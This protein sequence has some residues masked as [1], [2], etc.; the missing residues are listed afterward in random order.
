MIKI[1]FQ[2]PTH[3]EWINWRIECE[4]AQD[5]LNGNFMQQ[6]VDARIYKR[7][8]EQVYLSLTGPFRGKCAYCEKLIATDQHGDMEHYRPKGAVKDKSGRSI[9]ITLN[10]LEQGHPGYYWLAY[11]WR[12]LLPSC[13]LCNQGNIRR[14]KTWT[15]GKRNYFPLVSEDDRAKKPGEEIHEQPLLINPTF[16]DPESFIGMQAN[17]VLF[18]KDGQRG[19]GQTCIE[20]F[21]LNYKGLREERERTYKDTLNLMALL[22]NFM[23][24]DPNAA[25]TKDMADRLE[26]IKEGCEEFTVAARLAVKDVSQRVAPLM[27]PLI[28]L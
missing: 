6:E 16:E 10:D 13:Q 25:S 9:K 14:G 22:L 4:Q 23:I 26:R 28:N 15:A 18:A 8:K 24:I 3:E 1:N 17:G 11:D 12:N 19:R 2:E 27:T 7:M 5:A 21:G 20:T